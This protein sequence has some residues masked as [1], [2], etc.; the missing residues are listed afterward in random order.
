MGGTQA[1]RAALAR[2]V[3]RELG[4]VEEVEF[5]GAAP[6]LF[7]ARHLPAE[8]RQR[9]LGL[10]VCSPILTDF[11]ANYRREVGLARRLAAAGV[12]VQRFHPRGSGHSD[13]D[14]LELTF[15]TLVDDTRAAVE[16]I[17]ERCGVA[18]VALFG[19]RFSALTAAAVARDLDRSPVVLWEPTTRPRTYFREGLRAHGIHQVRLGQSGHKDPQAEFERRGFLDLLGIPVG[20]DLFE[21]GPSHLL[22]EELGDRPRPVLLVQFERQDSL[23]PDYQALIDRW[24]TL[25]FDI[26]ALCLPCDE[27]WWFIPDRL[28]W[29]GAVL[30]AT[31]DWLLDRAGPA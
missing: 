14:R 1:T 19:T 31:A 11:G 30:E 29:H 18:R 16:R 8:R 23:K 20:R 21:T 15:G 22:A 25:G 9:D 7:G 6:R 26:T 28:A 4:V 2:R 13:G 5:F 3:D 24:T 12:P 27:T 10:V 17:R